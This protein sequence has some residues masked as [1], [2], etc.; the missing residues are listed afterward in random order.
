MMHKKKVKP[1]E[2][3]NIEPGYFH[4]KDAQESGNRTVTQAASLHYDF[5]KK[6]DSKSSVR[7][8][9]PPRQ[10]ATTQKIPYVIGTQHS[11]DIVQL[12][13]NHEIA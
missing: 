7:S 11:V 9:P 1:P 3:T 2:S 10:G 6:M 4:Q 5:L 13:Y 8:A 12:Y